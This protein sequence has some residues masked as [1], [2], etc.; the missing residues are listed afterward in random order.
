[1]RLPGTAAPWRC[2][3]R[4][5]LSTSRMSVVDFS[6]CPILPYRSNQLRIAIQHHLVRPLCDTSPARAP[7]SFR[8]LC[9]SHSTGL[10]SIARPYHLAVRPFDTTR[11]PARHQ[12]L[13]QY[14]LYTSARGSSGQ[15]HILASLPFHTSV[16][17]SHSDFQCRHHENSN[18]PTDIARERFLAPPSN[19]T[20][21]RRLEH[22]IPR[23]HH[24]RSTKQ[25]RIAQ[26]IRLLRLLPLAQETFALLADRTL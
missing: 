22:R 25:A 10:T 9:R 16:S 7:D 12:A 19:E 8:C 14:H 6:P 5:P 17:P 20:T 24:F 21:E 2:P 18:G 23:L 3:A 11:T 13:H 1:M 15:A 4:Q 26:W